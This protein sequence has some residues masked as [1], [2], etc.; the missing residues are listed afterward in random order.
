MFANSPDSTD[1]HGYVQITAVVSVV[2]WLVEVVVVVVVLVLLILVV[3]TMDIEIGWCRMVRDR[4]CQFS[5]D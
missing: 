4:G 2:D 5:I 1:T 3:V